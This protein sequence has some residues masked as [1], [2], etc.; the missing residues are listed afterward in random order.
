MDQLQRSL[1]LQQQQ[2]LASPLG[3]VSND[4]SL[5]QQQQSRPLDPI[6]EQAALQLRQILQDPP[7]PLI[8]SSAELLHPPSSRGEEIGKRRR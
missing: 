3:A 5:Y 7:L 2:L 1:I 8:N 6:L 4:H